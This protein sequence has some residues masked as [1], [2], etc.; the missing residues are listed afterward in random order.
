MENRRG[1][2]VV[3][4]AGYPHE[5]DAFLAADPGLPSR[6]TTRI[7]FDHYSTEELVEILRRMAAEQNRTLGKGAREQA[8][9]WL[10]ATRRA[11]PSEF[12]NARTV[13]HL[14]ED[15]EG[16]MGARYAR[17]GAPPSEYLPE[18]VPAPEVG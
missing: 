3:I 13:R 17:G 5:I 15:M 14:L 9:A 2:L 1:H 8:A 10:E 4:A 7:P 18:D 12:G 16:G 11:C 6:F